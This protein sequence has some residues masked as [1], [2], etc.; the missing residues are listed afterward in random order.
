MKRYLTVLTL[1]FVVSQGFSGGVITNTNE[2][3]LLSAVSGGGTVVFDCDGQINLSATLHITKDTVLDASGHS[4]ILSGSNTV[5]VLYVDAGVNLTMTN[6]TVSDGRAES[7]AGL[8]NSGGSVVL[9]G[10]RFYNNQAVGTNG[11]DDVF[12]GVQGFYYGT[13][14]GPAMGGAVYNAGETWV[15]DTQFRTNLALGGRGGTNGVVAPWTHG[16][17][18]G[19]AYGGAI[20]AISNIVMVNAVFDFNEAVGGRGGDCAAIWSSGSG[21]GGDGGVAEGGATWSSASLRAT[22]TSFLRNINIGGSG[23]NSYDGGRGGRGKAGAVLN[24]GGTL[25]A[26]NCLFNAN[27]AIKGQG[28]GGKY[29]LIDN[30]A[31][32]GAICSTGLLQLVS[33]TF[34]SNRAGGGVGGAVFHAGGSASVTST[35]FEG[36]SAY[37]TNN[38]GDYYGATGVACYGGGF[39]NAATSSFSLCSFFSNTVTGGVGFPG[40]LRGGNG[41]VGLGGALGNQG[42]ASFSGCALIGN[43]AVGGA[44]GTFYQAVNFPPTPDGGPGG[45]GEGGAIGTLGGSVLLI[46]STLFANQGV[47]GNGGSITFATAPWPPSYGGAPGPGYAAG[48]Y[49][50]NTTVAITNCTIAGNIVLGGIAGTNLTSTNPLKVG[51]ASDGGIAVSNSTLF[52]QNTI[53]SGNSSRD[54][55]AVFMGSNNLVTLDARLGTLGLNGGATLTLPLMPDSPA[56]DAAMPVVGIDVDQRGVPRSFGAAPDIGA[57]EWNGTNFYSFFVLTKITMNSGNCELSGAGPTNTS[58]RL[59]GSGNLMDWQ[60]IQTNMTGPLGLFDVLQLLNQGS[61]LHF[62]RT[63]S[64]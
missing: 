5:G 7:G 9:A 34:L 38:P 13:D 52:L 6:L 18:G 55:D 62:Y 28:G 19:A 57:Y 59:Q 58:F 33:T 51:M 63:V 50:S 44:G 47:G 43:S 22:N 30:A 29:A 64:P 20:Y 26:S 45:I 1:L 24:A 15:F 14:G 3:N 48:I 25:F 11:V 23:G 35:L 49:A 8:F 40:Q 12:G 32:G 31:F 27:A 21:S 54:V 60:D 53:V 4:I 10:C 37:P 61:S 56:I 2:Q 16:G 36:N 39:F 41:G 46:N 42:T 17:N